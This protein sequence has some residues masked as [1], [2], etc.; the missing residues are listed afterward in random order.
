MPF[1]LCNLRNDYADCVRLHS[2]SS[3]RRG[4]SGRIVANFWG[5]SFGTRVALLV[6]VQSALSSG[7]SM[8]RWLPPTDGILRDVDMAQKVVQFIIGQILTDEE[9]RA[10][11]VKRPLETFSELRGAG[12]ELTNSEIEALAQTDRRLWELGKT[13]IDPRLRRYPLRPSRASGRPEHVEGR[14]DD[15]QSD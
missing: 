15:G 11:F 6:G 10:R 9:L 2:R 13:W 8:T 12:F 4:E 7:L 1:E 3:T 5:F 14:R